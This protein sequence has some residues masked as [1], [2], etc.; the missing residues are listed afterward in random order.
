MKQTITIEKQKREFK[1]ECLNIKKVGL[2][3]KQIFT[4]VML[5]ALVVGVG[6]RAFAQGD[7]LTP[8]TALEQVVGSTTT[9]TFGQT[10]ASTIVWEVLQA[11]NGYLPGGT[12]VAATSGTHFDWVTDATGQTTQAS[13]TVN[14]AYIKWRSFP[15]D[16]YDFYIVRMT[17]TEGSSENCST[18]RELYISIFDFTFDVW[19]SDASGASVEGT[20]EDLIRCN[21]WSGTLVANQTDAAAA[22]NPLPAVPDVDPLDG[23][24][25][26]T[27]HAD[28][29]NNPTQRLLK[30]TPTYFTIHIEIIGGTRDFNDIALRLQYSLPTQTSLDLY[31]I[32]ALDTNIKFNSTGAGD[33]NVIV[34]ADAVSNLA[35]DALAPHTYTGNNTMYIPARNDASGTEVRTIDYVFEVLTHN[36]LGEADMIYNA[37]VDKVDLDFEAAGAFG[38]TFGNGSKINY[39]VRATYTNETSL[40]QDVAVSSNMTVQQS[41]AT[42]VITPSY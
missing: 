9:F 38:S 13:P 33:D 34:A 21:T 8:T 18:I 19:I 17:E 30:V 27:A 14:T 40:A 16:P 25:I 39:A 4:L 23:A 7:G 41:P 2:M 24:A 15:T 11:E 29:V 6:S 12:T 31:Q 3:K 37:M 1:N 26:N 10:A 35:I 20:P 42:P 36:M 22:A 32:R 28:Y 5:L